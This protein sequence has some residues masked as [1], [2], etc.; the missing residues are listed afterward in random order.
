M[1]REKSLENEKNS[2]SGESQGI[3][4]SVRDN[5]EKNE[6][7]WGKVREF[8]NFPKKVPC[9]QASEKYNFYK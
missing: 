8:Q 7:S 6:K 5:L 3:S 2:R 1:V 4:I 9:L